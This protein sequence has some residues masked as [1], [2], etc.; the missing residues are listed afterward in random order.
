MNSTNEIVAKRAAALA[1]WIVLQA[2]ERNPDYFGDED[3]V[4]EAE[5]YLDRS[6]S[7]AEQNRYG[8]ALG[9]MKNFLGK[10][11]LEAPFI[12]T[13]DNELFEAVGALAQLDSDRK[14]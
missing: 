1:T 8:E 12:F 10:L 11:S 4:R 7:Y 14:S 5:S 6:F 3:L 13:V 2:I 9:V